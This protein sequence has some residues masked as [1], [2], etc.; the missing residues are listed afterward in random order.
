MI[1]SWWLVLS[2]IYFGLL[3]LVLLGLVAVVLVLLQRVREISGS[4]K[5]VSRKV[6]DVLDQAKGTAHEVGGRAASIAASVE[7][8][9]KRM[10]PKIEI[11]ATFTLGLMAVAKLR[12]T[13]ME[14]KRS[15]K[16]KA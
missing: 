3:I 9:T 14:K 8:V 6:E 7:G 5:S 11:F 13:L 15:K 10:A 4:I 12:Q 2:G 16:A 1:P